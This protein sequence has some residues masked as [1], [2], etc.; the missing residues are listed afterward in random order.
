MKYLIFELFSG[1]GLCNQLFSFETS[2]YLAN[3]LQRK[4]ILIIKNPLCHCG[5][6]TWDYGYILNFFTND[7]Y[8]YLPHGIEVYYKDV[9]ESISMHMNDEN[10]IMNDDK[11]SN[12]VFVD[13]HLY[14]DDN[15]KDINEYCHHRK[16][17]IFDIN[18]KA[19]SEYLYI[20][21]SNAS[22]CLYNFYT[23]SDN[24]QLM[25]DICISI[26]FKPVYYE[27]ANSIY[28][29]LDRTKNDFFVFIHL[30]FG[31]YH[32]DKGF[33]ERSN[34]TMIKNISEYLEGHRTNMIRITPYFLID[35]KN[36]DKFLQAMKKFNY[37][38][39]EDKSKNVFKNFVETNQMLFY[40]NVKVSRYEVSDAIIEMILASKAD[41]FIGYNSSTF[42]H[43]IQFL[44]FINKKSYYN[45]CNINNKNLQYCRLLEQKE[46]SIE[47]QRLNFNGGHPVS[48]HYFFR[49]FPEN[50]TYNFCIDNKT[51]GFGS[52]LQACF[53]LIAYCNYKNYNYI[54][55]PFSK[56]HHNDE[57]VENFPKVMNDF[58]NLENSFK[59]TDQLSNQEM[60]QI[61]K[62]KEGYFVHGSLK[63]EF[64]YTPQ[65]IN[66]IIS[67]YYSTPKPD[68]SETFIQDKYNIAIHIRRGDVAINNRHCVRYT[69]NIDYLKILDKLTLP[70]NAIFHIFSEGNEND[71]K[72]FSERYPDIKFH[73]S[74]NIQF[75]FHCLVKADLLILSKSSFCYCAGLLNENKVNG[76]LIKQWWHKPLKHWL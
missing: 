39:I 58:I 23:S 63:P 31:D 10:L 26:K 48:W 33:L 24:Y 15:K 13:K 53:S 27:I 74:K 34:S 44:R 69:N 16:G 8:K 76:E 5:R 45:Y 64:F 37:K 42:S 73:L 70:D 7:Y 67:C 32:K 2:I 1:V 66:K 52:Q 55:K 29:N 38:F 47:W 50:H 43:Y 25:Y 9:P 14:C 41:E 60:A 56:M 21:K 35:N 51:D 6:S 54:H 72:E 75:T 19:D 11:F 4:L 36:N 20:I 61:H 3:I 40:D 28:S 18:E 65:V 59:S 71:F 68:I 62:I 12:I 17:V 57:N 22:R 30:R 49:P 46:S